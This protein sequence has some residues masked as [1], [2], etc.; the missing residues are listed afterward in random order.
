[1]TTVPRTLLDLAAV[2]PRHLLERAMNEAEV[3]RLGDTL[4]LADLLDRHPGRRGVGA[5][6]AILVDAGSGE[7]ITRSELEDRFVA[8]LAATKLP[9]PELNASLNVAGR[10]MEV[11]CLWRAQRLVV[12]LDG[13]AFHATTV[14]FDRDRARDRL[15]SVAGW[16]VVRITWR[17]LHFDEPALAAG[18]RSLLR[19]QRAPTPPSHRIATA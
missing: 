11:D 19:L 6:R 17:Q 13:R 5:I 7:K 8:F 15:L 1:V 14:S 16:R 9:P 10:R 18:L 4:T 2:L 12:E 3:R